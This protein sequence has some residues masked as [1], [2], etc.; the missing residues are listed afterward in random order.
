MKK[1]NTREYGVEYAKKRRN[2]GVKGEKGKQK[3]RNSNG[4]YDA[5]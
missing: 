2:Q 4:F 5:F 3:N 1:G